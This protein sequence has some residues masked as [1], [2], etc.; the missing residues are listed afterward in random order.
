MG[1]R[2]DFYVGKG[3]DA[4]WLGSIAYDGTEID[5]QI[6][7]CTSPEAYRYA[8][9]SFLEDR[10]DATLPKDGWP[11]PWEDSGT[12]DCSY[13]H[14][15][16]RTWSAQGRTEVYVPCGEDRPKTD[17]EY[18]K[19]LEGRERI[20]LPNMKGKQKVTFGKRSGLMIFGR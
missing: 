19:M 5:D 11:W 10:D 7:E 15:D 12:T 2:A 8:V 20:E 17:G 4:E 9:A 14:F 16:G 3:K 1:T 13:W 18:E 6:R